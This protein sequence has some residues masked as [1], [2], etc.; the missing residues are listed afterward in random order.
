MAGCCGLF[1]A[2]SPKAPRRAELALTRRQEVADRPV[3]RLV[4]AR[5]AI[6]RWGHSARIAHHTQTHE[7]GVAVEPADRQP[8]H[9]RMRCRDGAAAGARLIRAH[10]VERH[11]LKSAL[12]RHRESR[13][14]GVAAIE[15][16]A[17]PVSD[18]RRPFEE[19]PVLGVLLGLEGI[20]R[21][22]RPERQLVSAAPRSPLEALAGAEVRLAQHLHDFRPA[23]PGVPGLLLGGLGEVAAHDI[24]EGHRTLCA[25]GPT[26]PRS[27]RCLLE[28]DPIFPK[29]SG[30]GR[31]PLPC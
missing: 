24:D 22:Q 23:V 16:I 1:K 2:H 5:S 13:F 15:Q 28:R 9:V 20:R 11:G 8:R 21:S 26:G 25:A 12:R 4:R 18:V 31:L 29:V 27:F 17:A 14:R 7:W 6:G 10:S 3:D 19:T 30:K